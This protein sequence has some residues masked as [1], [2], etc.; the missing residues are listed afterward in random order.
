MDEHS[1]SDGNGGDHFREFFQRRGVRWTDTERRRESVDFVFDPITHRNDTV[2]RNPEVV[3]RFYREPVR[4]FMI[5]EGEPY[6]GEAVRISLWSALM[7][8]AGF[9]F[10]N[11]E[12]QETIHTGIMGYDPNVP[13][14]DTGPVRR[15][16][17]S[18][19]PFFNEGLPNLDRMRPHNDF[20]GEGS[21]CL[22]D[23]PNYAVYA[24]PKRPITL[25]LRAAT[26]QLHRAL[27]Q[28]RTR[29]GP[30]PQPARAAR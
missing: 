30:I 27:P 13:S 29:P 10:H 4:P 24:V 3:Q 1:Y 9:V 17:L 11:D 8:G 19:Q 18:R 16:W 12:R 15:A 26:G 23:R 7:G 28:S 25:D 6:Q 21:Y 22:A 14:G 20:V 2:G 5:L